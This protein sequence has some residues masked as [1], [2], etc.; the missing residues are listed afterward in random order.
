MIADL[1]KNP[2]DLLTS[3]FLGINRPRTRE[4]NRVLNS[5]KFYNFKE[6][7]NETVFSKSPFILKVLFKAV[8]IILTQ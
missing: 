6:A 1:Q 5:K 7:G 2:K 4:N 3:S 8:A